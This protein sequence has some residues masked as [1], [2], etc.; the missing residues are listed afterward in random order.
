[1]PQPIIEAKNIS[2][3]YRLIK[4][5]NLKSG[6][7]HFFRNQMV[8]REFQALNEV[9]FTVQHGENIGVIGSNGSGKS[10]LLRILATTMAPDSG[11]IHIGTNSISLLALG[12]GFDNELSGRENIFLNGL[13]LGFKKKELKDKIDA[14][15]DFAEIGEFIDNP[16]RSYSSGMRSK[17]AFSISSNIEPELLLID[18]LF[19]VGDEKFKKKSNARIVE[20]IKSHRTVVMVSH[21]LNQIMEYCDKVLWLEKGTLKAFGD[22]KE[23]IPSYQE[24]MNS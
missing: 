12:I 13:L 11:S 14:I 1:M 2:L 23:I 8:T 22:P 19:S 6:L 21:N 4:R 10:T 18:E 3:K 20:M 9:S 15:I 5:S 7:L 17:L 24:F 16:V